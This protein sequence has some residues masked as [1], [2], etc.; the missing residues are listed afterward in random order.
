MEQ[1]L[2]KGIEAELARHSLS[3]VKV[4]TS[5][6][7]GCVRLSGPFGEGNYLGLLSLDLLKL[8][9]TG[10]SRE[11]LWEKL[12]FGHVPEGK[13]PADLPP[14]QVLCMLPKDE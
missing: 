7:E 12:G 9:P 13:T 8:N 2:V 10:V 14:V 6:V 11:L 5:P 4:E 3:D 1:D